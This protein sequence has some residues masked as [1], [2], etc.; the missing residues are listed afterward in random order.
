SFPTTLFT[1]LPA[2]HTGN[3]SFVVAINDPANTYDY[4]TEVNCIIEQHNQDTY[5]AAAE[6]INNS[7]ADVCLVQHEYGLFG[8][9]SGSY[10]LSLLHRLR[11]P[12][13]STLHTVLKKPS[14][15][16][17]FVIREV[18][19]LSHRIVVMAHKAVELLREHYNI[20]PAK[21][22]VV[23]HGVPD[24]RFEREATRHEL[25]LTKSNVL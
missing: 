8:G 20:S 9:Q 14:A 11:I 25:E 12:V 2:C 24:I 13:V 5:L 23:P 15:T 6:F 4:P 3:G 18:A 22:A 19:K 17:L 7:G 10:I 1:S 21:I 16:E